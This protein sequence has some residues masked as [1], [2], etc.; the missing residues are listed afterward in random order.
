[1]KSL[2]QEAT[3]HT[4]QF[5]NCKVYHKAKTKNYDKLTFIPIYPTPPPLQ[6]TRACL[7]DDCT[8]VDTYTTDQ[9]PREAHSNH[10]FCHPIFFFEREIEY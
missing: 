4:T 5:H 2:I 1:M 6:P 7:S 3:I 10:I 8:S 9:F